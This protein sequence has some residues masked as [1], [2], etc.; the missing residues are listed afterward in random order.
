M[1]LDTL[2]TELMILREAHGNLPVEQV[3][4]SG[5]YESTDG[6]NIAEGSVFVGPV[7]CLYA[8]C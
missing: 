3:S 1:D 5:R 7:I 4:S 2:I 8:E 6:P